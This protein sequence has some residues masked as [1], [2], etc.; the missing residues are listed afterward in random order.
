MSF[1]SA[2]YLNHHVSAIYNTSYYETPAQNVHNWI[3]DLLG[4]NSD[5]LWMN[6][7]MD[8]LMI[9]S[10]LVIRLFLS[11]EYTVYTKQLLYKVLEA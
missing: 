4:P 11:M 2:R 3:R 5:E 10:K 8:S 9:Y 6:Y 7:K 1:S